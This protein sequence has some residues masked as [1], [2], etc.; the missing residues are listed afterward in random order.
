MTWWILKTNHS[1]R[2]MILSLIIIKQYS[3]S[4]AILKNMLNVNKAL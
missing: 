3:V 2:N 4:K 1:N